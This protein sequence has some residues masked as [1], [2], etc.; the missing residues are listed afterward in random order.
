MANFQLDNVY[1]EKIK[2]LILEE[3]D[4]KLKKELHELH[5]ADIAKIL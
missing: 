4:K 3:K 5:Y 1:L 2:L